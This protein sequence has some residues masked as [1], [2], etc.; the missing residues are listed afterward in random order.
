[1]KGNRVNTMQNAHFGQSIGS[2]VS[3]LGGG[4][5]TN[6]GRVLVIAEDKRGGAPKVWTTARDEQQATQFLKDLAPQFTGLREPADA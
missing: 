1:M 2:I 6:F 4:D 3:D 5:V